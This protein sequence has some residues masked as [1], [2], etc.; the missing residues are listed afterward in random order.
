LINSFFYALVLQ[1]LLLDQ[2]DDATRSMNTV[3]DLVDLL[4]EEAKPTAST[5]AATENITHE[6]NDEDECLATTAKADS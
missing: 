4:A 1:A 2:V 6:S 5:S 3:R